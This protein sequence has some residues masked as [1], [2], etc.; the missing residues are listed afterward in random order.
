MNACSSPRNKHPTMN[1]QTKGKER[2]VAPKSK[3]KPKQTLSAHKPK[4]ATA[5]VSKALLKPK[6]PL[7]AYNLFYRFKRDKI[8][9]I[10]EADRD[11]IIRLVKTAPGLED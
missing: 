5:T 10:G 2:N 3:L 11:D 9:S 7:S 1:N 4:P 8:I 6:R